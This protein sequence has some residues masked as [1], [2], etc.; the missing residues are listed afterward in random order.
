MP[1]VSYLVSLQAPGGRAAPGWPALRPATLQDGELPGL[2][3]AGARLALL[4]V[5]EVN[6]TRGGEVCVT[7]VLVLN[8]RLYGAGVAGHRLPAGPAQ[9]RPHRG[10]AGAGGGGGPGGGPAAH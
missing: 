2:W 1:Q 10:A 9:A 3:Q 8:C 5:E 6:A 7:V 4:L